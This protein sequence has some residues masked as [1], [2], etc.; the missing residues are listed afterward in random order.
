MISVVVFAFINL[1]E[2]LIHY[3]IGREH[4]IDLAIPSKNDMLRIVT[5]MA[6]FAILQGVLTC[7]FL[8]C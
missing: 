2:N 3:T 6:V 4:R 1:I 8:N 7:Y 5:I